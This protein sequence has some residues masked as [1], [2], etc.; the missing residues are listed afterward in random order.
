VRRESIYDS[1]Q[2]HTGFSVDRDGRPIS[3]LPVFRSQPKVPAPSGKAFLVWI[4]S[5]ARKR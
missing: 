1:V 3:N 2:I 4:A 5:R